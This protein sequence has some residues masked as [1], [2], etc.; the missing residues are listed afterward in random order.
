MID[1]LE[2]ILNRYNDIEQQMLDPEIASDPMRYGQLARERGQLERLAITYRELKE[3]DTQL[4]DA[5]NILKEET[6][7]ELQSLAQS[8]I[9]QLEPE[10][11]SIVETLEELILDSSEPDYASLI[12]EIRAGTGGDEAALFA[13]ELFE[14]YSHLSGQKGWKIEVLESSSTELGGFKEI[15]ASI[16]GSGAY[17][18]LKFESGG[19]RVQRIPETETKGRRHTSMATV[20]VLPEPTEVDI[21]ISNDDLRIDTYRSSGPGGQHVNKTSSA[22][23]ITHLPT[24]IVVQC[25]DEKSQHKNKTKAMR[26][27]RSRLFEQKHAE[28]ELRR[29]AQ[30]RTLI[31]TGDRSQRIRTYNFPE[32]RV[33]DHRLGL[34]LY[35]LD[36]LLEGNLDELFNAAIAF[37]RRQRLEQGDGV[38]N[39]YTD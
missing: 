34:T 25:Q 29:S 38:E 30:R 7:P 37:D 8:E 39:L 6:D 13:R 18:V 22:I 31:G 23:R 12:M 10:R 15:I 24:N 17:R 11:P 32:N 26:V 20:A 16:S 1:R 14:M 19:H 21:Q 5:K 36:H 33:T 27:L 3:L 35:K 4:A 2:K 9:D 28:E